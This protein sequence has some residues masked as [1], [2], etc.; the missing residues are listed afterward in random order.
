MAPFPGLS[1]F[2]IMWQRVKYINSYCT[3]PNKRRRYNRDWRRCL[4]QHKGCDEV[5]N[6]RSRSEFLDTGTGQNYSHKQTCQK[7]LGGYWEQEIPTC[8]RHSGTYVFL[9]S[10]TIQYYILSLT[11]SKE[12]DEVVS[13]Q[14]V[15]IVCVS[16][17]QKLWHFAISLLQFK[18][19]S[20]NL[21][22][23]F[24]I[25]GKYVYQGQVTLKIFLTLLS[26]IPTFYSQSST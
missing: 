20:W 26:S 23:M 11:L 8:Q 10:C 21:E 13:C 25:K 6:V 7:W 1:Q 2:G 16:I 4:L 5:N 18:I 19:S 24:T 9:S 12:K 3:D 14:L 17:I 22:Y 15:V